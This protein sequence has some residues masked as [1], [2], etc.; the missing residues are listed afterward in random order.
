[1]HFCI[2]HVRVVKKILTGVSELILH[3][4]TNIKITS[5]IYLSIRIEW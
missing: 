5:L 4:H 1:M 3:H 2:Q